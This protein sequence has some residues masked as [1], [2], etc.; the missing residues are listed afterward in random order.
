[1]SIL[2]IERKILERNDEVAARNREFFRDY[3]VLALNIVSSPGA[4]K[5]SLL[6]KTI[7]GLRGYVRMAVIEGD[8]Q[9]DLDA[10]RVARYEVPVVQIIT[11]GGC[12][13]EAMLV[14]DAI[15]KMDLRDARLLFIENVGNLVCPANYDLGED[16]KIVILSVTEGDDK[17][18]KYPAMVRNASVLV[19]NKV[20]LLPY[21]ECSVE[22]LKNNAKVINPALRIFEVSAKTGA[23]MEERFQWLLNYSGRSEWKSDF[24]YPSSGLSREL[25]SGP[26]SIASLPSSNSLVG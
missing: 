11:N 13:L 16:M 24:E 12:H 25:V 4:G 1:M 19:I 18:L 6:E 8:V 2:T 20:D 26:S 21:L 23:G 7:V 10:R 22:T 17:P 14:M 3:G 5:T 9:T 15:R